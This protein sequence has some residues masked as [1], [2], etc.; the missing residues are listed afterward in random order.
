MRRKKPARA[1]TRR[2]VA[3]RTHITRANDSRDCP[4]PLQG[5][6]YD[7][8]TALHYGSTASFRIPA[9]CRA[10]IVLSVQ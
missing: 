6:A 4:Q 1:V 9:T 5:I 3:A 10:A 2:R 8:D 7:A